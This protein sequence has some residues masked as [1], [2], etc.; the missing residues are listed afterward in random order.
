MSGLPIRQVMLQQMFA[1]LLIGFCE[2]NKLN[3]MEIFHLLT[4]EIMNFLIFVTENVE[5]EVEDKTW[6][7]EINLMGKSIKV[8]SETFKNL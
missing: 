2:D 3:N 8:D 4:V 5:E 1:E 6:S 7:L